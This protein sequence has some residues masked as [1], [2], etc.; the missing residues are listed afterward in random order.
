MDTK[1]KK[2]S[3]LAKVL[4]ALIVL[5]PA[6]VIGSLY[7][8]IIKAMNEEFEKRQAELQETF[9][10][11]ELESNF[12]NYAV[13]ASYYIYG[14]MLQEAG[15]EVDFGVLDWS[16]WSNDY[17]M[18]AENTAF[19]AV[20][21]L[22]NESQVFDANNVFPE[23]DII[24]EMT[25]TFGASGNISTITFESDEVFNIDSIEAKNRGY[26]SEQQY[27]GNVKEYQENFNAGYDGSKLCPK[28]FTI[29]FGLSKNNG[30]FLFNHWNGYYI[31][32]DS[33]LFDLGA[34]WII[35][36]TAVFVAVMAFILPFFKRLNTGWE[37]A[38]CIPFE[39]V[40]ACAA[41]S[42]AGAVGLFFLLAQVGFQFDS[43]PVEF[44]GFLVGN[45]V[46]LWIL[47]IVS[48]IGWVICFF[49]EYLVITS[50]RQFLSG[51]VYYCKQRIL[52]VTFLRWIK[53]KFVAAYKR[54][55]S[56]ELSKKLLNICIA[57]GLINGIITIIICIITREEGALGV[58]LAC[59]YAITLAF[60]M[61]H[62]GDKILRQYQSIV[63]VTKEMADGNLKVAMPEDV[64]AFQGLG[65]S[66]KKVQEGFEKAVLEEAKSQN[67][68]TELI[69]NVS[70]DLKTPLTAIITYVDLLKDEKIT[71]EERKS[72]INTLEQKSQRLK[73]L[74]EDLFEVSKATSGNVVMNYMDV[75][76]IS[77]MKQVKS[78][79][80]DQID[81]SNL[82]FR[83]NL[84]EEKIIL[85]L[86]GQRTYR[87]F[88]N[89]INNA[90]KYS[91]PFTRVY[92]DILNSETEVKVTFRNVSAK[93]LDFDPERLTERFVR[94][95]SSRNS[96][97]SGLGL[98][99]A[100]S[101]VELQKGMFEITIDGDLFKVI[102]T[103]RK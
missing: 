76:I 7:P 49:L 17:A 81:A 44:L 24:C 28:N 19:H 21:Y 77:L 90:I 41:A 57:A 69:T 97:G 2:S 25:L 100:K 70:H 82:D 27:W 93:E 80:A 47:I 50:V 95:D 53:R 33:L 15:E 98:A 38:F 78:E 68:K 9:P 20:R 39:F 92:I 73:V 3:K 84:P 35:I 101:F 86:D 58:F 74:I 54:I 51:P 45:D 94:G 30:M 11:Y 71:E 22:E 96:E 4:I 46:I 59:I 102:L 13:E 79:M 56:V 55:T 5:L 88:E 91:L 6:L 23:E 36:I 18:I 62:F 63:S 8:T 10:E 75:D 66:I 31:T 32:P 52:F 37:K 65:D 43:V 83:F 34:V 64:S 60:L 16:G 72:Y 85:S 29:S 87:V 14:M 1:S 40:I 67:M 42:I 48:T 12:I 103:W 99:I 89:L 61:L 26:E